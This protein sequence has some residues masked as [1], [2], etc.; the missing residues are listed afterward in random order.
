MLK[1]AQ[2]LRECRKVFF[3]KYVSFF[4]KDYTRLFTIS[5]RPFVGISRHRLLERMHRP[6]TTHFHLAGI[7]TTVSDLPIRSTFKMLLWILGG[8]SKWRKLSH[9]TVGVRRSECL[10]T[11]HAA[12]V[13]DL[14]PAPA[15]KERARTRR[16]CL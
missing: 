3:A 10:Q 2:D 12:S 7:A 11:S 14:P 8:C 9:E 1:F 4:R 6:T 15:R 13:V 16:R 5:M